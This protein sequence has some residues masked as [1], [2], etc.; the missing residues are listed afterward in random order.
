MTDEPN[1]E[2][3]HPATARRKRLLYRIG[4]AFIATAL[5]GF[6]LWLQ[7]PSS[8]RTFMGIPIS[9]FGMSS[10]PK[11]GKMHGVHLS[12]PAHYLFFP[13]E[14]DGEESWKPAQNKP[15][16]TPDSEIRA[17]SVYVQWPTLKPRQ[18][19]NEASYLESVGMGPR[20]GSMPNGLGP[21]E[22]LMI[23]VSAHNLKPFNTPS[24]ENLMLMDRPDNYL[25]RQAAWELKRFNAD[26][27]QRPKNVMPEV[28]YELRDESALGLKAAVPVGPGTE[29]RALWNDALYWVGTPGGFVTTFIKCPHGVWPEGHI[30]DCHHQFELKELKANI[31]IT[32]TSNWLSDWQRIEAEARRLILSFR[33]T[34]SNTDS[35][36][37]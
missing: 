7:I 8:L 31:S 32:Y 4:F 33:T 34:P 13:V 36:T 17:F 2:A 35:A 10:A 23:G 3:P 20:K 12:I 29:Q 27:I 16:R 37:H 14:Y 30:G 11:I 6:Y 18:P 25:G 15:Q 5:I 22:W 19:D 1:K 21:H 24:A 9:P 28:H 26:F